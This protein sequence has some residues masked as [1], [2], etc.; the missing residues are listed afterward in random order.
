[1]KLKDTHIIDNREYSRIYVKGQPT[2]L[3]ISKDDP[4]TVLRITPQKIQNNQIQL[5]INSY[6]IR[7]N[8]DDLKKGR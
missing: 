4:I 5:R 2:K 7:I 8:I 1:M 3:W 6:P